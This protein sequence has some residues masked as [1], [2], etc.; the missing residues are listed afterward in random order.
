MT[1]IFSLDDIPNSH[2]RISTQIAV[3]PNY[4]GDMIVRSKADMALCL[5][6]KI[7]ELDRAFKVREVAPEVVQLDAD[8]IV[9]TSEE[10][11]QLMQ[12]QFK[13]GIQHAQGF[14]PSANDFRR[15]TKR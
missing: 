14:V 5:S 9:M 3:R 11:R 12:M 8:V 1:T 13:K 7:L 4:L 6:H 2:L 15:P 10:F